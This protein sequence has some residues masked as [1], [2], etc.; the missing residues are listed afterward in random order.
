MRRP[1]CPRS[2]VFRLPRGRRCGAIRASEMPANRRQRRE[3]A[4]TGLSQEHPIPAA[5]VQRAANDSSHPTPPA[6][7]DPQATLSN[8]KCLP[9][10]CHS[11]QSTGLV[12][13]CIRFARCTVVIGQ[14][15]C[16]ANFSPL[17]QP[18]EGVC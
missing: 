8:P 12:L 13:K 10:C 3:L 18:G 2:V 5:L 17:R 15:C 9:D 14:D 1:L 7:D 16:V 6:P 4:E 11:D